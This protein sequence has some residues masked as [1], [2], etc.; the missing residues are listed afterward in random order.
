MATR[1]YQVAN[2]LGLK[3]YFH[4]RSRENPTMI[5]VD[6]GS[7]GPWSDFDDFSLDENSISIVKSIKV[8]LDGFDSHHNT[9]ILRY[10]SLGFQI[11]AEGTDFVTQNLSSTDK[12]LSHPHP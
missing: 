9:V 6:R 5:L 11:K 1:V 2:T 3:L 7:R 8:N 12:I 4:L 10:H